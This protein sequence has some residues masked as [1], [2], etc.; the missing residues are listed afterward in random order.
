MKDQQSPRDQKEK[1]PTHE[2]KE[3]AK[4]LEPKA[5]EQE[6]DADRAPVRFGG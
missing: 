6:G 4:P 5:D 3:T 1:P 2:L